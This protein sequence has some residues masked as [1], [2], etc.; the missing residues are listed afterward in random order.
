M[1]ARG[2]KVETSP[3]M[4]AVFATPVSTDPDAVAYQYHKQLLGQVLR[5]VASTRTRT[6]GG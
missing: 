4:L 5:L 1:V 3:D 2:A 6:C